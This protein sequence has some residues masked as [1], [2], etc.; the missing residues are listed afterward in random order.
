[1]DIYYRYGAGI[2]LNIQH[3]LNE[4]VDKK[5]KMEIQIKIMEGIII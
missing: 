1:M 5:S 2:I 3:L 4:N